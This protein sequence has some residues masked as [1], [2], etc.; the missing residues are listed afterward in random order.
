M[1][2]RVPLQIA[3]HK[4]RGPNP[5]CQTC[6]VNISSPRNPQKVPIPCAHPLQTHQVPNT[7]APAVPGTLS[8]SLHF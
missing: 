8:N 6:G 2:N 5:I 1:A 7:M 3:P 4:D